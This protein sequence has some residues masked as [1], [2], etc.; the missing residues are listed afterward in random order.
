MTR[1][2]IGVGFLQV[3]CPRCLPGSA[4]YIL[5]SPPLYHPYDCL[6]IAADPQDRGMEISAFKLAGIIFALI[7]AF[8]MATSDAKRKQGHSRWRQDDSERITLRR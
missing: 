6:L 2:C 3:L 8:M 4:F 5:P 1:L 7:I